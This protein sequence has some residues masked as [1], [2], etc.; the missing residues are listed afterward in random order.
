M[1]KT[2]LNRLLHGLPRF[3]IFIYMFLKVYHESVN[4]RAKRVRD[5]LSKTSYAQATHVIIFYYMPRYYTSFLML[6]N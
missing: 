6:M 3:I 1:R 2:R 5:K 4:K